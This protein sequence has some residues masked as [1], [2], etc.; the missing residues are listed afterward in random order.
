MSTPRFSFATRALCALAAC[1]CLTP[2]H[3]HAQLLPGARAHRV[4][5]QGLPRNAA[6]VVEV[7]A[8][9]LDA[10][11]AE[12][13][14]FVM[15]GVPLA[16]D[17]S[18]N[19]RLQR[20]HVTTPTT[21]F[22]V[23]QAGRPDRELDFD[24]SSVRMFRGDVEGYS[25][26]KVFIAIS[27]WGSNGLVDLGHG[28][29]RYVFSSYAPG[30]A[31]MPAG[32]L[33]VTR[34]PAGGEP[35]PDMHCTVIETRPVVTPGAPDASP[36]KGLRQVQLAL[37][38]D[39]DFYNLF[40]SLPATSAYIVT[41]YG[42]VSD[43]FMSNINTRIDLTYV[44][45][46]DTPTLP[47]T[48]GLGNFRT[49]W[50]ANMSAVPRDVAQMSSGRADLPG[51]SAYLS[52]LCNN[53]AYSF[54]GNAT[55]F[56]FRPD[57]PYFY[58]YDPHV[59]THELGHNF[60]THHTD[61]YG[62]DNCNIIG[63]T[64]QRGTIMSY[65]NQTVS[66]GMAVI[67]LSFHKVTQDKML[68]YVPTAAC[69]VFDCNQNGIADGVD[70]AAGT[71]PDTNNNGIPDECEDCNGNG[72]LDPLDIS[73][74]TSLDQN[75]NGIPDEC[76]PDCNNNGVPDDRDIL[77][78]ISLDVHGDRIPDE[79][80]ADCN[81]NGTSDY[82][83]LM[84]NMPLDKNRDRALD[85]CEDCDNDG[86]PDHVE[87]EGAYNAFVTSMMTDGAVREYHSV[88]GV[89]M[90][91]SAA[92]QVTEGQDLIVTPTRR[93]LV[94]SALNNR[95]VEFDRNGAFVGVLVPA[96]SGGLSY[97][98]GLLLTPTGDL[99]V[100]SRDTN[101]VLRYNATTGAFLGAFVTPGSGGLTAP[102]GLAFG[103]GGDLFVTS[104]TNRVL[105]YSGTTGSFISI[106]VAAGA[107]GLSM[108]RGL[109]FKPTDGNLLVCSFGTNRVLEY[110]G[111]T[112]AYIKNWAIT[113][114]NFFGPWGIRIAPNGQVFVSQNL[115]ADT[116]VTKPRISEFSIVNGRWLRGYI[117]GNDSDLTTPTGFDFMPGKGT[118]CNRNTVPDNCDIA[119]GTSQ[120]HNSNGIP[121]ECECYA[122]CNG[123]YT[124]TGQS[125]LN[126]ADFGCFQT[127]FASQHPYADCNG[128]G[129]FNLGDFGCFQTKFALGCP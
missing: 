40:G 54:C 30:G 109:V 38:T 34:A 21:R 32:F 11:A 45:L 108:P 59:T 78:G 125:I 120:D 37:E 73:S 96:G 16:F 124:P 1:L 61:T 65:C 106:F 4:L 6:A 2:G 114:V 90:N 129:L 13:G 77:L 9:A 117:V 24:P 22:V 100:A 60:G 29:P 71:S 93:V 87:L 35:N 44:R 94:S 46:W 92:G 68:G 56:M 127:K 116:H 126:L 111:T 119:S 67:E 95:V 47:F 7:D 17:G 19:L 12:T 91:K 5:I 53:N 41:L 72:V 110:N 101:S 42:L 83:E 31:P 36:V 62:L 23:G 115:Q 113:G 118:D 25:G 104:G 99:L 82:T 26:S 112:G 123:D 50:N 27:P 81:N 75:S 58:N 80:E 18:A 121:D 33:T 128:D 66:G 57:P 105:R 88:V 48:P 8:S 97:P 70:I 85:A 98:T 76:E 14:K 39:F 84:A 74:G 103:P 107:G 63:V 102:F 49:Y 28:R 89:L 43:V 3:A 10:A 86:V 52:S 64:P 79:C 15:Q 20:L 51:G 69:V 55:G 122:N